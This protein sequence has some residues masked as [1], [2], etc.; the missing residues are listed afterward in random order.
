MCLVCKDEKVLWQ[1]GPSG[2]LTIG[3]CPYCND[4][5]KKDKDTK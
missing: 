2:S 4:V 5:K 3:P 1:P